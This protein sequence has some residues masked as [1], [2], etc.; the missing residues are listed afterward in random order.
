MIEWLRGVDVALFH[1]IN[2]V[3][4]HPWL[5]AFFPV[6]TDLHKVHVFTWGVVP[7]VLLWWLYAKR[8][9]ALKALIGI[10]LA[11]A[12]TDMVSHR[13][14]KRCFQ[15]S[16][17]QKAGVAV[18]LRTEPHLGYSFP[19]NH[20]SNAFAAAT[21]L[22][23]AQP[24]LVLAAFLIA[25]L[26]AYSRVYVGVHFPFDVL[27]GALLGILMGRLVLWLFRGLRVFGGV[28]VKARRIKRQR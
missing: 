22:A 18:I 26:V 23:G 11:V 3:W 24:P 9:E 25:T 28:R 20:A 10:V 19:S 7:V 8:R 17:P 5:D 1:K 21:F 13:V 6:L 14:I 27:G 4:T 2:A 15:R 12:L 16:R